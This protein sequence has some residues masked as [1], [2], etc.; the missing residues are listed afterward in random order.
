MLDAMR[1]LWPGRRFDPDMPDYG[2]L[3]RMWFIRDYD[4]APSAAPTDGY[5]P[6]PACG[7]LRFVDASK[8]I[9]R[10]APVL[11]VAGAPRPDASSAFARPRST[12]GRRSA[13]HGTVRRTWSLKLGVLG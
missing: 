10:I 8:S 6:C 11:L 4:N 9:I 3:R 1:A 12:S 7:R 2:F 5:Y 13:R